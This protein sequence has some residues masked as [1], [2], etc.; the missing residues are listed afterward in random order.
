MR[1]YSSSKEINVFVR[2]LVRDGWLFKNGGRH[3]RLYAP[4]RVAILSVPCTPSD[5]RAVVNFKQEVRRV[6]RAHPTTG[7]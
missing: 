2:Q 6:L 3:G 1:R 7:H 4:D 5:T